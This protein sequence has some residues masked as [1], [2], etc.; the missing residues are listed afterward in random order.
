MTLGSYNNNDESLVG[1]HVKKGLLKG[2][3]VLTERAWMFPIRHGEKTI[4]AKLLEL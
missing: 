1:I 3:V 2:T 4:P